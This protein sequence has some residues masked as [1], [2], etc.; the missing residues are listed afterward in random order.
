MYDKNK[1]VIKNILLEIKKKMWNKRKINR[2][3]K[4]KIK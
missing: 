1:Q 4:E 3:K 2:R